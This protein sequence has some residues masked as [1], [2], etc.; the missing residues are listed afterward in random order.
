MKAIAVSG[1]GTEEDARR[2]V[3]AGFVEHLVKPF[4]PE[5][6]IDVLERLGGGGRQ[7]RRDRSAL[8]SPEG[9]PSR[10]RRRGP[11]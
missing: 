9:L 4:D 1:Y 3:E 5:R 7:P 6:L 11:A 10:P 8:A 2:S